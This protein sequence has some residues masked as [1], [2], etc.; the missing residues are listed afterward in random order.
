MTEK[1]KFLPAIGLKNRLIN[2]QN[3]ESITDTINNPF[4]IPD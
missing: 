2:P 3:I 1:P 4:R